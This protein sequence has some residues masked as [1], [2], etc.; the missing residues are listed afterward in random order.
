[1]LKK[2]EA[3]IGIIVFAIV[4]SVTSFLVVSGTQAEATRNHHND[5]WI[6]PSRTI[7]PSTPVIKV[8]ISPVLSIEPSLAATPTATPA[9]STT[10]DGKGDGLS[11]GRSDGQHQPPDG[12]GCAVHECKPEG[13]PATGR[14]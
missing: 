13:A 10:G 11:D 5:N 1:M 8:S 3:S 14:Q 7:S 2:H 6:R 12:L 9:T 4:L